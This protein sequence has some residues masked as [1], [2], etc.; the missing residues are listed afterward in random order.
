M[1]LLHTSDGR[2]FEKSGCTRKRGRQ[3]GKLEAGVRV[4]RGFLKRADM[5]AERRDGPD[6]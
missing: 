1:A 6:S 2:P 3:R 5:W 4:Q